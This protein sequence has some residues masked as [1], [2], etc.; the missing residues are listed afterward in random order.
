MVQQKF[1]HLSLPLKIKDRAYLT[2]GGQTSEI[3]KQNNINRVG[4]GNFL[5]TNVSSIKSL[6]NQRIETR[7]RE[8]LPQLPLAIPILLEIDPNVDLD[9]LRSFGFEIVS[10]QEDGFVVVATKDVDL[11]IFL[12]RLEAFSRSLPRSGSIAKVHQLY[13]VENVDL[14]LSR[15]LSEKLYS[16][17]S[18]IDEANLYFVDL[19]IECLGTFVIPEAIEVNEGESDEH[20]LIR[21]RRWEVKVQ[22]IY[23]KVDELKI[24]REIELEGFIEE[25]GGEI[26]SITEEDG[27]FASLSDSFTAR[28]KVNGKGLKDISLNF[29]Y[30]FEVVEPEEVNFREG[31][32]NDP[33][34]YESTVEIIPPEEDAPK[35]CIIDSGISEGHR[36]L[37]SAIDSTM[38]TCYLPGEVDVS[39]R[40]AGG[41]HGTRV[42]GAVL[43]PREIPRDGIFPIPFWIQNAR[44]LNEFNAMPSRLFPPLLLRKIVEKFYSNNTRIYNHS[45]TAFGPFK[46]QHMSSWAAEMDNLSYNNDVL[47]IQAAGNI[48]VDFSGPFRIGISQHL[49]AGRNYPEYLLERSCRMP[50]PAQSLQSITVGSIC[51]SD[52]DQVDKKSLGKSGWPSAFSATGLGI[53]DTIKPDVVEYGGTYAVDNGNPA[54]FTSPP[55]VCPELLRSSPPAFA[56]DGIGTSFAAPKVTHIAAMIQKL[57]PAEPTLLY[58][59]LIAQSAR[60]PEWALAKLHSERKNIVRHL[61]YGIPDLDRATTNTPYRVTLVTSGS[62]DIFARD[63]HIYEVPVPESLRSVGEEYDILVEITLSYVAKPRRTRKKVRGYLSSWLD[64]KTS[65]IGEST[66]SFSNRVLHG[67]NHQDRDDESSIPWTI[68]SRVDTGIEGLSR[69]SSTLQKDW[70]VLKSH[71]LTGGFNIAVIGHPGWS[72]DPNIK[73]AYS[74]VVS[75]EAINRD[76]EIYDEIRARVET[77][78]ETQI[79]IE[80]EIV[81]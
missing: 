40:V 70:A 75:F 58:R 57:L 16:E 55:E 45:I 41:G 62:T 18:R 27:G 7:Q 24:Q 51:H 60:W 69:S 44:V 36:L 23:M 12:D 56:N 8:G 9:F 17:W 71:Q 3:T 6:W 28:V 11:N 59:A 5:K 38:S 52:L 33:G 1:S 76:I 72:K 26:I 37:A 31:D 61:G 43:Y 74:L 42:A 53:W 35:V 32:P 63:A 25:H 48:Y 4:H 67:R 73:A 78:I 47:F 39:D 64:W 68:G 66:D 19:G 65:N 21:Q 30:I 50:S 20:L 34:Q 54:N 49:N 22:D 79:E 13:G 10:E 2:G 14:R 29:P 80:I 46:V 81:E 15:I 77:M